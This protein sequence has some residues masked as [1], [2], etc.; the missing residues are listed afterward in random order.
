MWER[1]QGEGNFNTANH[2]PFSSPRRPL[3]KMLSFTWTA[4]GSHTMQVCFLTPRGKTL[5]HITYCTHHGGIQIQ[6][7]MMQAVPHAE[8]NTELIFEGFFSGLSF[9]RLARKL[10]LPPKDE[11]RD[12]SLFLRIRSQDR[13]KRANLAK[14]PGV[15]N[16]S[17]KECWDKDC[18]S[19]FQ[20]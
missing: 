8:T 15:W 17:M 1:A 9:P 11:K 14:S 16:K 3:S 10:T 18:H 20:R 12:T 2:F 5:A 6:P 19:E 4:R 13:I 7:D